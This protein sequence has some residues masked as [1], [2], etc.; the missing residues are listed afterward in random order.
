MSGVSTYERVEGFAVLNLVNV[1]SQFFDCVVTAGGNVG[2]LLWEMA[3]STPRFPVTTE[4]VAIDGIN[5]MVKR[6]DLGH[7]ATHAD[8]GIYTCIN[9]GEMVSINITEGIISV[10]K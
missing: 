8:T 3:G 7:I 6:L 1:P 2:N 5:M 4:T 10:P 9:S